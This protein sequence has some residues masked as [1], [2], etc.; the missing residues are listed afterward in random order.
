SI[1]SSSSTPQLHVEKKRINALIVKG[2]TVSQLVLTTA[3][4]INAIKIDRIK[5]R[6]LEKES[7]VVKGKVI[8]RGTIRKEVFYVD[9]ENRV[10]FRAEDLPFSLISEFPGLK[11]DRKLEVQTHLLDAKVDFI[12]HPARHCLPG[13]L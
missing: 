2:E 11:P 4:C 9:P 7:H 5:A 10:R 3:T 8:T 13:S 1:V 12:L 6:L